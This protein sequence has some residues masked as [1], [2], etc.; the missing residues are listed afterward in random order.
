MILSL[1]VVINSG[2]R[3][4]LGGPGCMQLCPKLSSIVRAYPHILCRPY[5]QALRSPC[6]QNL[7]LFLPPLKSLCSRAYQIFTHL[8]APSPSTSF[9]SFTAFGA[10]NY[11]QRLK[12]LTCSLC[13]YHFR[14]L[15]SSSIC[16]FHPAG[17]QVEGREDCRYC[18]CS[19]S[20]W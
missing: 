5:C 12:V 11:L 14:S 18:N 8:E 16:Q 17:P 6:I 9:Q 2:L 3:N 10:S 19:N 13:Q 7:D 15:T 4:F 20:P 1:N